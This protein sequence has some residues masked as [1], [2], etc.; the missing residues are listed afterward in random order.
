LG[1]VI[2]VTVTSTSSVASTPHIRTLLHPNDSR[3]N[4]VA[5]LD[6]ETGDTGIPSASLAVKYGSGSL[7]W[8]FIGFKCQCADFPSAIFSQGA[9][10]YDVQ[11]QGGFWLNEGETVIVQVIRGPG[12][13][14]SRKMVFSKAANTFTT[15]DKNFTS[16]APSSKIAIW[17][18]VMNALPTREASAPPYFVL[19]V[20]KNTWLP[21][22]TSGSSG[23]LYPYRS[24][25]AVVGNSV[26]TGSDIPL[27]A[28]ADTSKFLVFVDGRQLSSNQFSA[29]AGSIV[30]TVAALVSIDV[31]AFEFIQDTGSSIY[32]YEAVYD[33][34]SHTTEFQLPIIPNS[35]D[36]VMVF[37]NYKLAPPSEYVLN[38]SL[39]IFNNYAPTG[40]VD[41]VPFT[42]YQE[43][44]VRS[45]MV[46]DKFRATGQEVEFSCT[47][48]F[49]LRKDTLFTVDGSYIEKDRYTVDANRLILG[50]DLIVPSGSDVEIIN[51]AGQPV[52]LESQP[53]GTNTGPVWVDPAGVDA[54]GKS[55]LMTRA[56]VEALYM[57]LRGPH[58][59]WDNLTPHLKSI[60][61]CP[62]IKLLGL[63]TGT[64][65][66]ELNNATVNVDDQSVAAKWGF[67]PVKMA[68][69][70]N[71]IPVLNYAAIGSSVMLDIPVSF[72]FF[73]LLAQH[74]RNDLGVSSFSIK[75][76]EKNVKY[77]VDN[78]SV[79]NVTF[80]AK[81]R[82]NMPGAPLDTAW[83][84]NKFYPI[85][86]NTSN[87][88]RGG[89]YGPLV[90]LS[91]EGEWWCSIYGRGGRDFGNPGISTVSITSTD[92]ATFRHFV[93]TVNYGGNVYTIRLARRL[94][95]IDHN[96]QF[97]YDEGTG[98]APYVAQLFARV[99]AS[100]KYN[101][102][103]INKVIVSMNAV[104]TGWAPNYGIQAGDCVAQQFVSF[105]YACRNGTVVAGQQYPA[106][107]GYTAGLTYGV[108]VYDTNM[109]TGDAKVVVYLTSGSIGYS[110][111][112]VDLML[113]AVKLP[114]SYTVYP[115]MH[116]NPDGSV[117]PVFN[118]TDLFDS[119]CWTGVT[120]SATPDC[121]SETLPLPLVIDPAIASVV[122]SPTSLSTT[123]T[124]H[125]TVTGVVPGA[126]IGWESSDTPGSITIEGKADS[127]GSFTYTGIPLGVPRPL[128]LKVYVDGIHLSTIG[129]VVSSNGITSAHAAV[130]FVVNGS[131]T[132]PA[133]VFSLT[134][135][136]LGAGGGGGGGDHN[137]GGV[138]GSK[139]QYVYS[140]VAVVPGEVMSIV[141]GVGGYAGLG[142]LLNSTGANNGTSGTN[143]VLKHQDGT[144][145]LI[146][147]GGLGGNSAAHFGIG[148]NGQSS[149]MGI[150]GAGGSSGV[151]TYDSGTG[152]LLNYSSPGPGGNA[153]GYGAA[154]GGG[155]SSARDIAEAIL[156]A[157]GGLGSKGWMRITY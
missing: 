94:V 118:N 125:I 127:V 87:V 25:H 119:C 62:L 81:T 144:S 145:A 102:V 15:V 134:V 46:R 103:D 76:V 26:N 82:A 36:E 107:A 140:T 110:Q 139:G 96:V 38:G 30:T 111:F 34:D 58:V 70:E 143:T 31:I 83:V 9:F 146:A 153:G 142:C 45:S 53:T 55:R 117:N 151:P 85:G 75:G 20:G 65:K 93:H 156:G 148:T 68:V 152:L 50:A 54:S 126:I 123:D 89:T 41:L 129:A 16:L 29:T 95:I 86:N 79:T 136:E 43:L 14:E 121:T 73:D 2:N 49:G 52:D 51:F 24:S 98:G 135:E 106:A 39:I 84:I 37:D 60:L 137:Y 154:G 138:G 101:D 122:I 3:Q 66:A 19:G 28:Y 97:L 6:Q 21:T 116:V 133:N 77:V 69:D 90:L 5:V 42:M 4:L 23:S 17:R 40:R 1:E 109:Q 13:G 44:G 130:E 33:G 124:Y 8:A 64:I 132:I 120:F 104:V 131:F 71:I 11:N 150:G 72:N 27:S 78:I 67:A 100:L 105:S 113:N 56:E 147:A 12:Q 112:G 91:T 88:Q 80:D 32:F 59:S 157:P 18:D 48:V 114:T 22:V 61:A 47:G 57:P 128:S 149:E 99:Y 35:V 155:G 108:E 92:D 10:V 141:I 63:I 7:N 74:I 115:G